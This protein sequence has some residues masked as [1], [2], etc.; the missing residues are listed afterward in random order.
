MA[1]ITCRDTAFAYEGKTVVTNLN[2]A[3]SSGDYICVVGENGSGKSTLV[4]GLVGLK[5]PVNGEVAYGEGLTSSDIGYMPQQTAHQGDFPTS[6]KEV[7]L[8]GRLA[9]LGLRPF[10]SAA[11]RDAAAGAMTRLD[12]SGISGSRFGDL[13]GGQKQRVLLARAL[14]AD[15]RLLIL[16]EPAAGL[17]PVV[18]RELY[19]LIR[20]INRDEKIALVMVSHDIKSAVSFAGHILHLKNEQAFFGA[21]AD[22]VMS[23]TGA[24]F[25]K[26][27]YGI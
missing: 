19:E 23:E 22:Y 14:C 7:V 20:D 15:K 26:G 9:S 27:G 25:L 16:D 11:D 5:Q 3:V 4:K 17:D 10:Y 6:V 12:I 8:S 2:F 18:T 1:L 24:A 21:T 13:S